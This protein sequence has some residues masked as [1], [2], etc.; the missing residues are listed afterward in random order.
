MV[1]VGSLER[2]PMTVSCIKFRPH[3]NKQHARIEALTPTYI[4]MIEGWPA[5]EHPVFGDESPLIV[6]V[7][8]RWCKTDQWEPSPLMSR[9][10]SWCR[11]LGV[12]F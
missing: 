2:F 11:L 12:S 7:N 3:S 1:R 10:P 4:G 5:Y 6:K 8:G 9:S